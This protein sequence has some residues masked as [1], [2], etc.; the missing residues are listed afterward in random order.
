M[1]VIS[2]LRKG[3][4]LK[5]PKSKSIRPTEDR[6]K[7]SLFN[8]LHYVDEESL[9]LDLCAGTG[10]I[11]IEFLS[12]G[13]KKVYFVDRSRESIQCIKEN[14]AHTRLDDGAE[15]IKGDAIKSII[16]F[17]K[18]GIAFDYIFTDPPYESVDLIYSIIEN[19]YK[20]RIL[21]EKGI[22]IIEHGKSINLDA[23]I[24]DFKLIDFR[25]YKDTCLSFYT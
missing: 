15:V 18:R 2:G 4:R 16:N 3:Y 25:Q 19:I 20:S 10:S 12:R 21:K 11:G 9:V 22:L 24:C 17:G 6:I 1:R 5:G 14:L 7:E 23:M 8:I 13:A